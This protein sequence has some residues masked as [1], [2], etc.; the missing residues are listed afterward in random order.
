ME[1]P[2]L[3]GHK[4]SRPVRIG[5][6]AYSQFQL[7][8]YGE[9]MDSVNLYRKCVGERDEWY[10]DCLSRDVSFVLGHWNEPDESVSGRLR[11]ERLHYVFSKA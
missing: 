5:N 4:D 1:V 3:S 7:D 6:D 2:G 11:A 9:L 8:V 10:L